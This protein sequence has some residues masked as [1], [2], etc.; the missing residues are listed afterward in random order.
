MCSS[1]DN[2]SYNLPVATYPTGINC[3]LFDMDGT[4]LDSEV[5]TERGVTRLLNDSGLQPAELDMSRLHGITWGETERRLQEAFPALADRDLVTPLQDAFHLALVET[6]PPFIRGASEALLTACERF[7]AR[8]GIVTSSNRRDVDLL[9]DRL[10][11]QG[12]LG[13]IVSA[14]DIARSKPD[15]ECYSRAVERLDCAPSACLVFEDSV[16]GLTSARA[17]GAWTIGIV[18]EHGDHTRLEPLAD[19][20]IK[21]YSELPSDFFTMI[22]P[23]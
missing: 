19:L 14:E 15:P 6:P 1:V 8:A 7:P 21:D 16:A 12:R 4:L 17:A 20:V 23:V 11:L 9:V 5:L 18:G 13:V 2:R 10:N 3:V 22:R